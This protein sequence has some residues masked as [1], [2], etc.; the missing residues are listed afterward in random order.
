MLKL[1][2]TEKDSIM[3]HLKSFYYAPSQK[4]VDKIRYLFN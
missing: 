1:V 2:L 3:F 4:V